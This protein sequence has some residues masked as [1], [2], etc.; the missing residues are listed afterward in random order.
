[1]VLRNFM[2]N[3]HNVIIL[4]VCLFVC[5]HVC[6]FVCLFSSQGL[7][8]PDVSGWFLDDFWCSNIINGTGH[9]NDPVQVNLVV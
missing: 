9:C 1:M 3:A 6:L 2:R 7:G 5:L 8:H 4:F